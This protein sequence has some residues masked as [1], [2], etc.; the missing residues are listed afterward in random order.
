MLVTLFLLLVHLYRGKFRYKII[1][2]KGRGAFGITY[3]AE[4]IDLPFDHKCIVKRL[5]PQSPDPEVI[6]IATRLF[7]NESKHLY[8]LGKH[9]QI[10]CLYARFEENNEFYLVQE[11]VAG[12]G[13]N[14]DIISGKPWNEKKTIN[15]L[16]QILEVLAVVHREN[17]IHRDIKPDNIIRRQRDEKLV[18]ID[19]GAVKEIKYLDKINH[20]EQ[21]MPPTVCIGPKYMPEEQ[22]QGQPVLA[23]DIFAVGV[24]G[25]LGLTGKPDT[26]NWRNNLQISDDLAN[27]LNKM[28]HYNWE[29]RYQNADEVIQ[30]INEILEVPDNRTF[31]EKLS[32]WWNTGNFK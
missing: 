1:E 32:N 28:T 6:E 4:D 11:Y 13:L 8:K 29:N 14:I 30:D 5:K 15:I 23:S 2:E 16:K 20:S 3:L 7:K 31:T 26:I 10:P 17:L 9:D 18:L 24:I 27:I 19:F 25:I 22:R 21:G 12:N